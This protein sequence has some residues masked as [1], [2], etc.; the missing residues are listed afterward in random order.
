MSSY[1]VLTTTLLANLMAC[2]GG[3]TETPEPNPVAPNPAEQPAPAPEEVPAAASEAFVVGQT[4]LRKAPT[5]DKKI[6]D[7]AGGEKPISNYVTSLNRGEL[8]SILGADGEWSNV[9]ASDNSEGWI[10]TN[11]FVSI[12]PDVK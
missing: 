10:R 11:R 1:L 6:P 8:V 12:T 3:S 4:M 9:R 7:P 5:D 2:M